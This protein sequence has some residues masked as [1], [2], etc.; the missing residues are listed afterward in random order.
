[1]LWARA[2]AERTFWT[3][4]T[5]SPMRMA[6]MAITTS[7]SISVKSLLYPKRSVAIGEI[8]P[9]NEKKKVSLGT[10]LSSLV[11]RPAPH[12]GKRLSPHQDPPQLDCK[13]QIPKYKWF[14]D[15]GLVW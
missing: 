5:S 9:K 7:N 1:M 13:T 15:A 14:P 4:G 12:G 11:G 8:P 2:A 10:P 3:A 6:I